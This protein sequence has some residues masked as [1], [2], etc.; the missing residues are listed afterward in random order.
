MTPNASGGAP[1][2]ADIVYAIEQ[3]ERIRRSSE[4]GVIADIDI[5]DW[6]DMV[7]APSCRDA[8]AEDC[9]AVNADVTTNFLVRARRETLSAGMLGIRRAH[10]LRG[11]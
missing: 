1:D 5:Q 10:G 9:K 11:G 2:V 3:S 7:T 8:A 4:P 6:L